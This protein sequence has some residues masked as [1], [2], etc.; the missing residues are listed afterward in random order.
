MNFDFL[1]EASL[2]A[3]SFATPS[4]FSKI[5]TDYKLVTLPAGVKNDKTILDY[6]ADGLSDYDNFNVADDELMKLL[7]QKFKGDN[8][9]SE[10]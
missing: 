10:I 1:R 9:G 4:R 8:L 3:F 2:R 7:V 5:L 6:R